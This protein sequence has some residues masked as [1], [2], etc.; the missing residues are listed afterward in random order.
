M[1]TAERLS[2]DSVCLNFQM[3]VCSSGLPLRLI[4]DV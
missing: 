3:Y 2:L 4:R 1:V